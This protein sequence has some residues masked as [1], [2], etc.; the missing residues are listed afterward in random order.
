M[1]PSIA[2]D[3]LSRIPRLELVAAMVGGQQG[4]PPGKA[5]PPSAAIEPGELGA[6]LLKIAVDFDQFVLQ[7]SSTNEA[8]RKLKSQP[9][10]YYQAAVVALETLSTDRTSFTVQEISIREMST[11]M[12]LSEDLRSS[13]GMLMVAR[14]QEISYPLL[15]RIRN[16]HAKSP[17]P[18]KIRVKVPQHAAPPRLEMKDLT[19]LQSDP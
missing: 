4:L 13:N 2:C 11:G 5:R 12:I 17:F 9:N 3:L 1:H 10:E 8:I 15:V 19:V 18:G 7:G 14:N 6:H 16:L